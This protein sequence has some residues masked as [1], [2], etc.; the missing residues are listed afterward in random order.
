MEKM[1]PYMILNLVLSDKLKLKELTLYNVN[2]NLID[3]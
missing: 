3:N 1:K 2:L